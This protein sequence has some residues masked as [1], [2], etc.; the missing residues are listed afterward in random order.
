MR[1]RG[2]AGPKK[3]PLT[4]E[5]RDA[6]AAAHKAANEARSHEEIAQAK[7]EKA[8]DAAEKKYKPL[9][10][11]QSYAAYAESVKMYQKVQGHADNTLARLPAHIPKTM[12]DDKLYKFARK[13]DHTDNHGKAEA[14]EALGHKTQIGGY[15]EPVP[16][17]VKVNG[18]SLK[19]QLLTAADTLPATLQ[20]DKPQVVARQGLRY[21]TETTITGVG[22]KA[23]K[24][25]AVTVAVIDERQKKGSTGKT[26]HVTTFIP[27]GKK[28]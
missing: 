22:S 7:A 10:V 15:K 19:R 6:R 13:P 18:D 4:E 5:Q 26:I 9:S 25:A 1:L 23:D 28:E 24:K 8:Q 14:L 11:K 3:A 27:K 17:D 16:A 2:G 21:N 12:H 20:P